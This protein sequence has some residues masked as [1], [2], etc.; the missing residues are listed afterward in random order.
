MRH[1]PGDVSRGGSLQQGFAMPRFK[2]TFRPQPLVVH[3]HVALYCRVQQGGL[4]PW[5][6]F[7]PTQSSGLP[8]ITLQRGSAVQ[9]G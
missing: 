3:T 9:I 8:S 4:R 2:V 7:L 5:I 6:L 1:Q